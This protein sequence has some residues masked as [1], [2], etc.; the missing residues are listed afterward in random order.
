MAG[1]WKGEA[2]APW[3]LIV[4]LSS[5]LMINKVGSQALNRN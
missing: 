2:A 3:L 1:L 4:I 5:T